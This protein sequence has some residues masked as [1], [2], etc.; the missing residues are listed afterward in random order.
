MKFI[1]GEKI[2]EYIW[3]YKILTCLVVICF[4]IL[5]NLEREKLMKFW[6]EGL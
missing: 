6:K 3:N 2:I 1:I 5:Y 4:V